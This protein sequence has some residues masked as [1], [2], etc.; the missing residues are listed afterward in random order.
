MINLNLLYEA[1]LAGKHIQ[2]MELTKEAIDEKF[3]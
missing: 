3:P 1:V 2:A